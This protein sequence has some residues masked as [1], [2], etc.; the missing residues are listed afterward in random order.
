MSGRGENTIDPE[1]PITQFQYTALREH[2][3]REMN[4][5]VNLLHEK[6]DNFAD[7]IHK[8]IQRLDLQVGDSTHQLREDMELYQTW[9]KSYLL[10][11]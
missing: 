4:T 3:Q 6:H 11:L 2:L 8:E 10:E 7:S 1:D 9:P 5:E